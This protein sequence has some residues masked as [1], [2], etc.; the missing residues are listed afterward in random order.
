MVGL[1]KAPHL[2][3]EVTQLHLMLGGIDPEGTPGLGRNLHLLM[4]FLPARR[5]AQVVPGCFGSRGLSLARAGQF[6]HIHHQATLRFVR[7]GVG[8]GFCAEEF[9]SPILSTK[10]CASCSARWFSV[11]KRVSVRARPSSLARR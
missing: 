2:L 8:F 3:K 4:H 9:R 1:V 10:A 6:L 7:A 11:G 5:L